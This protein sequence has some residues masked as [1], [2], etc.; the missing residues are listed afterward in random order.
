[1]PIH[2]FRNSVTV[3]N[4]A[5]SVSLKSVFMT[6]DKRQLRWFTH[7]CQS[8]FWEDI[9]TLNEAFAAYKKLVLA[10]SSKRAQKTEEGRW[11][12]HLAPIVGTWE[13]S[14]VG[15]LKV[16][17]LNAH[18]VRKELAPQS[19]YHCLSL[20]RRVLNR[21]VE[22]ELY[23]G[24]VPKIRM[25]KFDN[26][27]IRFLN[28]AEAECLLGQLRKSSTLWYDIALFALNT[29]L[30][31][32]ELL[33]LTPAHIDL[34]AKNCHI[35]DTKSH[36]GRSIPLNE[37]AY[38]IA[39]KYISRSKNFSLPL[40]NDRSLPVNPHSRIFRDA[41][42]ACAFNAGVTD[43]RA[44]VCFHTLR[45]TFASWLVQSGVRLQVVAQLLGHSSLKMTLRYAHLAP[46]QGRAAVTCLPSL[47][48]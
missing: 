46:D 13:L 11:E 27:R 8:F 43:R 36:V 30:R 45:H 33:A 14:E 44:R 28:P 17:E 29:G 37:P 47:K 10:A 48:L 18:L 34:N 22:W 4:E 15:A 19:V 2:F 39:K 41:V 16:S 7:S 25:P 24:P 38:G 21:A 40:F 26:R 20:V 12:L 9:M 3:F 31:R 6:S 42:K 23:P 1:M 5:L 32:G 35:V